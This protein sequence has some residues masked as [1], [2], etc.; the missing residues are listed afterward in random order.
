MYRIRNRGRKKVTVNWIKTQLTWARKLGN[1]LIEERLF[2]AGLA[3]MRR[4]KKAL[5]TKTYLQPRINYSNDVLTKQQT[6]LDK[7]GYSDG[8]VWYLDRDGDEHENSLHAALG[9]M[10]WKRADRS[11]S[12]YR[13]CIGPS[14][15]C[16][17]Q[18]IPV[19]VWGVLAEGKLSIHVLEPGE[20]MNQYLYA[21]LI[22]EKFEKWLLAQGICTSHM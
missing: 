7:W 8:T 5:V 3:Y 9:P 2:E 11:D 1:T 16:K 12:L 20:N 22:T 4:R 17:G 14:S 10:V 15:Y 21:E 19:K 6:T 18:G 13:D